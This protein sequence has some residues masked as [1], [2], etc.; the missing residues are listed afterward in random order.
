MEKLHRWVIFDVVGGLKSDWYQAQMD[1]DKIPYKVDSSFGS[2]SVLKVRE[3]DLTLVQRYKDAVVG[4]VNMSGKS[5]DITVAELPD[6]HEYFD[7]PTQPK[8]IWDDEDEDQGYTN[9]KGISLGHSFEIP[10]PDGVIPMFEVE[11]SHMS[12]IGLYLNHLY[13]VFKGR[14]ICY[15]Y[16][17][18]EPGPDNVWKELMDQ[19]EARLRGIQEASVGEVFH[20]LVKGPAEKGEIAVVRTDP[21]EEG[22]VAVPPKSDRKKIREQQRG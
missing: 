9:D 19:R 21:S 17:L 10:T 6:D 5:K 2:Q 1:G 14:T 16:S 18:P 3:Q 4:S 20:E 22:W 11:S 15:R 12:A 7:G 8:T 13:V